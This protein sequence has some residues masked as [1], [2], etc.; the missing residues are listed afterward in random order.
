MFHQ[1]I[2]I[3]NEYFSQLVLLQVD[4]GEDICGWWTPWECRSQSVRRKGGKACTLLLNS[5]KATESFQT[6]SN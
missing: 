4:L 5:S 2:G 1:V 3:P 6:K